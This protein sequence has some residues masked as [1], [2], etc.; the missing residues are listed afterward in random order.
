MQ[1]VAINLVTV[2]DTLG[3][4]ERGVVVMGDGAGADIA[5]RSAMYYPTRVQ[6][7]LLLNFHGA[8]NRDNVEKNSLVYQENCTLN[9][10]NVN[11]MR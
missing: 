1:E 10:N 4:T 8:N 5:A 2:L 6:G 11:W 7:V 3:I 9:M